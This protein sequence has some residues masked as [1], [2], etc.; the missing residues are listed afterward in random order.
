[1]CFALHTLLTRLLPRRVRV[2][3][4]TRSVRRALGPTRISVVDV[5]LA[6]LDLALS[7]PT[8]RDYGETLGGR[9]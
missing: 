4:A 8:D 2:H 6:S 3:V 5:R 1:M 9:S 7:Q